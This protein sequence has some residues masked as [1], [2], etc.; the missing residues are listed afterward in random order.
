MIPRQFVQHNEAWNLVFAHALCN[1]QKSDLLPGERS[2]AMLVVRNEYL[3]AS[4]HPLKQQLTVQLGSTPEKRR[5][6][7]LR[8]YRDVKQVMPYTWEEVGGVDP[9]TDVLYQTVIRRLTQ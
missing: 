7:V 5:Q 4:N 2:I 6:T 9:A 8:T 3:V 1:E